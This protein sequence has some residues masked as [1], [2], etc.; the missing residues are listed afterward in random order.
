MSV[1]ESDSVEVGKLAEGLAVAHDRMARA[2]EHLGSPCGEGEG[3][4]PR[5][6]FE[7]LARLMDQEGEVTALLGSKIAALRGRV[8]AERSKPPNSSPLRS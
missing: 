3:Q 6:A 5:D 7:L 4:A 1:A 8:E 2:L